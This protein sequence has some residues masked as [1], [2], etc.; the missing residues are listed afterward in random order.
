MPG[1]VGADRAR[2]FTAKKPCVQD[3]G[4]Q[5]QKAT[6]VVEFEIT[7]LFV[8]GL[9][10]DLVGAWLLAH[11]LI[12]KPSVIVHRHW[13]YWPDGLIDPLPSFA[14]AED[15][16]D[17]QCGVVALV[18]GFAFQAVGYVL[19]LAAQ[20]DSQ[21]ST[22]RA[23]TALALLAIAAGFAVVMWHRIRP[24]LLHGLLVEMARWEAHHG[25]QDPVRNDNANPAVLVRWEYS[26]GIPRREGEDDRAYAKRVYRLAD[27]DLADPSRRAREGGR[28]ARQRPRPT[29]PARTPAT[30]TRNS[31][32]PCLARARR[33]SRAGG[34]LVCAEAEAGRRA[35][36][37]TRLQPMSTSPRETPDPRKNAHVPG[38]S[39]SATDRETIG[40]SGMGGERRRSNCPALVDRSLW[41][42]GMP[43]GGA[44]RATARRAVARAHAS[45]YSRPVLRTSSALR[46]GR[47]GRWW[48]VMRTA[49]SEQTTSRPRG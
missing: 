35:G 41:Q 31:L 24:R 23:L 29:V 38:A 33:A 9:G 15:H 43:D 46:R 6:G 25:M 2:W 39:A 7:D 11:G 30:R 19:D 42:L 12:A 20:G 48:W 4:I 17:G 32:G 47:R 16:V 27:A 28:P 10:F 26:L 37:R 49:S 5:A 13:P 8:V 36:P 3:R 44:R 40:S 18:V 14:A 45:R 34:G 22:G 1:P 21:Q